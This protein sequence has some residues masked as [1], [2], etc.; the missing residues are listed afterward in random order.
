MADVTTGT[1][2]PVPKFLRGVARVE[3]K[4]IVPELDGDLV[5]RDHAILELWCETYAS[6]RELR[7]LAGEKG[8]AAYF[9]TG[10]QGQEITSPLSRAI[11]E[12]ASLLSSL[13][14]QLGLSPGGRRRLPPPKAKKPPRPTP[15]PVVAEGED[16]RGV[17]S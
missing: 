9:A 11:K 10:A 14:P 5:D 15:P 6:L 3:W 16:P 17:L 13:A 2:P 4:R 7:G 1:A 8:S 12:H